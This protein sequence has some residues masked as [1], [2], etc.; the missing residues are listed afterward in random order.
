MHDY[1]DTKCIT[2]LRNLLPALTSRDSKILIDDMVLPDTGVHWHA[3]S[4]D[5]TMMGALGSQERTRSEFESIVE[6]VG[7]G[8]RIERTVVYTR[9]VRNAVMVLGRKGEGEAGLS[10]E[11]EE[12]VRV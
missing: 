1:S 7:G 9:P 4:M 3:T 6:R 5:I 11:F 2:I 8:L 12:K 10:G